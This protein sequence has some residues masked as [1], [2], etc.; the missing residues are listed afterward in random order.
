MYKCHVL[1]QGESGK[2]G[3][4]G[5]V[6]FPGSAVSFST[7]IGPSLR[8]FHSDYTGDEPMTRADSKS[9]MYN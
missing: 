1:T 8:V 2:S 9:C 5:E 4:A 3:N 7:S 6:G